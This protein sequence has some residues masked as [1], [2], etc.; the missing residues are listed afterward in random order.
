MDDAD[1]ASEL[2]AQMESIRSKYRGVAN[3]LEPDGQCHWC[4]ELVPLPKKFCD[5]YCADDYA[6]YKRRM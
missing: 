3:E 4:G 6:K 2:E 5:S 1:R